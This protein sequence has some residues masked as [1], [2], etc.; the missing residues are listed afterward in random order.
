MRKQNQQLDHWTCPTGCT[1][2]KRPE[3]TDYRNM[4]TVTGIYVEILSANFHESQ[5]VVAV[6]ESAVLPAG[7]QA[8]D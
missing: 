6:R 7:L 2:K 4:Y 8:H 5:K 1:C 3:L